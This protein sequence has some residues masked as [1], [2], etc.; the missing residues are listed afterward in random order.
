MNQLPRSIAGLRFRFWFRFRLSFRTSACSCFTFA[1]R[2]LDETIT[3]D[4]VVVF[5]ICLL[6]WFVCYL[7]VDL[8]L[9]ER[10]F[11]QRGNERKNIPRTLLPNLAQDQ[12]QLSS[13]APYQGLWP[14]G[15]R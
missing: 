5:Y 11:Q 7:V 12:Q 13:S 1:F 4:I 8:W 15:M 2:H 10:P 14:C 3:S 6:L 9:D